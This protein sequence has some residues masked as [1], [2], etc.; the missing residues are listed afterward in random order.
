MNSVRLFL[1]EENARKHLIIQQSMTPADE[2]AEFQRCK[3][4]N[5]QWNLEAAKVRNA[6]LAEE[7]AKHREFIL[8]RLEEKKLR[9]ERHLLEIETRVRKEKESLKKIITRENIDQAIEEA[10]ASPVDYNFSI[11]MQGN[12]Y[13]GNERP[14]D[15]KASEAPPAIAPETPPATAP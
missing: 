2:E 8:G 10:L 6:R 4:L 11:D 7:H 5:D 1:R 3:E 12:T 15:K 9:D 14:G 13:K